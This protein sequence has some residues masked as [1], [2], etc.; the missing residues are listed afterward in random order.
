[1]TLF[2]QKV[3]AE[4]LYYAACAGN[5]QTV[6]SLMARNDFPLHVRELAHEIAAAGGHADV[7]QVIKPTVH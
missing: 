5:F 2:F 6:S 4:N 3:L 7:A 1:M